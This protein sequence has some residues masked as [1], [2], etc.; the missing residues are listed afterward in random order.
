MV[1]EKLYQVQLNYATF[2]LCTV[3]NIITTVAPIGKWMI[4]KNITE[5]KNWIAYKKG[6]LIEYAYN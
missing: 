3:N 4:G 2:G 5:I 1:Q 6:R